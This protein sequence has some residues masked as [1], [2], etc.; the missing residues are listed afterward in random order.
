MP[1]PEAG[2]AQRPGVRM[3]V[4]PLDGRREG[5]A[6]AR[7]MLARQYPSFFPSGAILISLDR[8][9]CLVQRDP[10]EVGRLAPYAI[11]EYCGRPFGWHIASSWQDKDRALGRFDEMSRSASAEGAL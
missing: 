1:A 2:D 5:A 4:A 3:T 6:D 7:R 8:R 9:F 10:Q 11:K